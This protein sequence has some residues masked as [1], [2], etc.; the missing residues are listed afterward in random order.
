[1][2]H[3]YGVTSVDASLLHMEKLSVDCSSS[4]GIMRIREWFSIPSAWI[5]RCAW[6]R[7]SSFMSGPKKTRCFDFQWTNLTLGWRSRSPKSITNCTTHSTHSPRLCPPSSCS[8]QMHGNISLKEKSATE[9][10]SSSSRSENEPNRIYKSPGP[11]NPVWGCPVSSIPRHRSIAPLF[12]RAYSERF[13]IRAVRN[14]SVRRRSSTS[15]CVDVEAIWGI[16]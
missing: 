2:Q 4:R 16:L 14:L 7:P 11:I 1:M 6:A 9:P 15:G 10:S 3:D 12:V 8:S 5:V 13:G